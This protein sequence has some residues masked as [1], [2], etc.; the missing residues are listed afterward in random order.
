MRR[1]RCGACAGCVGGECGA[2]KNCKD[3]PK[4]GRIA[5]RGLARKRRWEIER[6][7]KLRASFEMTLDDGT[8]VCSGELSG[9]GVPR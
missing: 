1:L 4:F 8:V 5:R 3:K 7:K 6:R 2:C 9:M